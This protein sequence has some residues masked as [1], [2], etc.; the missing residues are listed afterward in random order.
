MKN[1]PRYFTLEEFLKSDTAKKRGIDN[2][3][4]FEIVEHLEELAFFLDGIREAWG[5]GI[6]INSGYR[7][8]ILN[9]AVGGV[10]TSVHKIGYAAD[11]YP[12]NGKFEDFKKFIVDYLKDKQFDQCIIESKAGRQWIHIGL[13]NNSH[14]QRR[15]VFSL[16]K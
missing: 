8:T 12:T 2:Y 1:R 9:I 14:Q 13:R 6:K 15:K 3:P 16:S 4:T 11:I 5:S 7:S 10:V